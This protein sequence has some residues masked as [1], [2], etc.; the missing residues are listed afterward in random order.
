[1]AYSYYS[2]NGVGTYYATDYSAY[3]GYTYGIA[4]SSKYDAGFYNIYGYF[5]QHLNYYRGYYDGGFSEINN[6]NVKGSLY[7]S[8]YKTGASISYNV[9]QSFYEYTSTQID[10]GS[11]IGHITTAAYNDAVGLSSLTYVTFY[12]NY[13]ESYFTSY[14][15]QTGATTQSYDVRVSYSGGHYDAVNSYYYDPSS[16]GH[17]YS[18]TSYYA[19]GGNSGA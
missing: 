16:G 14:S 6:Y 1:M 4:F 8:D 13:S 3:E 18:G 7:A 10:Y 19:I 17:P 12:N 5:F 11:T 9:Y 15:Y 2:N